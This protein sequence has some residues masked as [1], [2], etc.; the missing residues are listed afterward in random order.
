MVSS[1][2]PT[3]TSTIRS[4]FLGACAPQPKTLAIP[5]IDDEQLRRVFRF[6]D[7]AWQDE[8]KRAAWQDKEHA[9]EDLLP[10]PQSLVPTWIHSLQSPLE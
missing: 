1:Q 10:A 8:K 9:K 4:D 3:T 6:L 5:A 2:Q 7:H